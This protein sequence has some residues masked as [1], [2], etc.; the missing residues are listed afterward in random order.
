MVGDGEGQ[1]SVVPI[2]ELKRLMRD[3]LKR[4]NLALHLERGA[5]GVWVFSQI[6]GLDI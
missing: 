6:P 1:S 3:S 5:G 2:K 4:K